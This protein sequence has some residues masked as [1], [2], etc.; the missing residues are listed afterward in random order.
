VTAPSFQAETVVKD[1]NCV[2]AV[3]LLRDDGATLLQLRDDKPT[4]YRPNHWVIPGGHCQLGETLEDCARRE[5][6]EE[7]AYLCSELR[8]LISFLDEVE[9]YR[10]WLNIFWALYD[11]QQQ[12]ECLEGQEVRFVKREQARKYLKVDYLIKYWDMALQ[13]MK[14]LGYV[15]NK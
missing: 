15:H 3:Y 14:S 1:T 10:Y 4:I 9:G 8:F 5:F 2:S 12:I 13:Q 6:V 11:G 7:T